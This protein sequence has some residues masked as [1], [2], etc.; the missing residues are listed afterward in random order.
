MILLRLIRNSFSKNKYFQDP[1]E[2][3]VERMM[4]RE[5]YTFRKSKRLSAFYDVDFLSEGMRN[6]Q[7]VKG[8]HSPFVDVYIDGVHDKKIEMKDAYWARRNTERPLCLINKRY[9]GIYCDYLINSL[10]GK[11]ILKF[12]KVYSELI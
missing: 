2:P 7:F 6:V 10:Y 5:A 9:F 12:K 4:K 8:F 1:M 11:N 3:V